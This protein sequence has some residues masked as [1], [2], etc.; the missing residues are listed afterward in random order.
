MRS[1]R[2]GPLPDFSRVLA[3]RVETSFAMNYSFGSRRRRRAGPARAWVWRCRGLNGK[4]AR[5]FKERGDL[6]C[7]NA[8]RKS[9]KVGGRM[10]EPHATAV[11]LLVAGVLIAIAVLLSRA[12]GRIGIPVALG[13]LTV[14]ILAGSE[15]IGGIAFEDY[16][17]TLRVGATAL[18]LILFDG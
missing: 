5:N 8:P 12:S 4:N 1:W 10:P 14:G 9:G 13:F 11:V 16:R 2:A 6:A 3:A 17:L 15:G 18:A 7:S